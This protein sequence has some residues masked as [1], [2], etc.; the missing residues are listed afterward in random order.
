[1]LNKI[2]YMIAIL[3]R[4]YNVKER[5]IFSLSVVRITIVRGRH[6]MSVRS[7]MIETMDRFIYAA[8]L[9]KATEEVKIYER[10]E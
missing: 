9:L 3:K 10:H 2:K 7:E 1:M 4:I 8:Y 6:M 5:R